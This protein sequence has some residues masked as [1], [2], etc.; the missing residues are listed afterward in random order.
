MAFNSLGLT[1]G[2]GFNLAVDTFTDADSVV[3]GMP[4]GAVAF[5]PIDGP[6]VGVTTAAGL[7]VQAQAGAA[8]PVT[9]NGGSLTVDG[10]FWQATQPVSMAA[11]P[12]GAALDATLTGGSLVA[13]AVGDVAN[14][15]VDS[16]N[17]VKIGGKANTSPAAVQVG[18]RVDLWCNQFGA[19]ITAPL[20]NNSV[21][22]GVSGVPWNNVSGSAVGAVAMMAQ[23]GDGFWSR[24][25]NNHEVTALASAART[26]STNSSDLTSY[27]ARGVNVVLDITAGGGAGSLT[28]KIT[29]KDTLSG[30]YVTLFSSG[31]IA[32]PGVSTHLFVVYPGV[33]AAA[34]AAGVGKADFPLPRKWRVEVTAA[35]A[36]SYTYS[37]G[38]N[39]IL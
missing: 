16:G 23:D 28:V 26:A 36:T 7:P 20:A 24:W 25:R 3:R 39:Y 11:A 38:A 37:I 30:K 29:G 32:A 35:D 2:T 22:D 1:P 4:Y 34:Y 15:G 6:Y 12:T 10:T 33:V 14:D 18:D 13:K 5:G 8:F 19:V 31:A 9:D 17:P 27:N 21:G